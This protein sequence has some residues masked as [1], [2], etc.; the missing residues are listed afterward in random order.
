MRIA[1]LICDHI[2]E[3]FR[4]IAGGYEA[5]YPALLPGLD[6]T[7]FWV[8]DGHFPESFNDFDAYLCSGSRASVYDD[9]EWVRQLKAFVAALPASGQRFV[10]IC[11][12]H[13]ML[14]EALGGKVLPAATGWCVGA[15]TFEIS[16]REPW[17]EPFASPVRLPMLCQ[18]QVRVLP[19]G[20]TVLAG[21]ADCPVGMF[22]VGTAMLGI[23]AHPEF[24]RPYLQAVL[25]D[26]VERI[27]T[28]K[29]EAALTSLK[30]E[31]HNELV[32]SWI[33]NFLL[34]SKEG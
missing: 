21:A 9:E 20:S 22:S 23:Q 17:M 12:G 2:A 6:F 26:R 7:P 3:K 31:L 10:G 14:A 25:E 33:R 18:D 15:H 32:A 8:C 24:V 4:P 5:M 13:Q 30:E 28:G 27:G 29:T 11:F 19:A 1:L 34:D 16:K